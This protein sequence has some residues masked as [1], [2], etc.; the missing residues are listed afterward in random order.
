VVAD[1]RTA[2][3]SLVSRPAYDPNDFAGRVDTA[4][5]KGLTSD[6]WVPLQNR[7]IQNQFPPGS[8][9]KAFVTAATLHADVINEHTTVF[10]PGSYW[11]GKRA[12]RCWKKGGHGT[13]GPARGAAEL[14]ATSSSTPWA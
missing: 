2:T 12:Y 8:T 6:P 3:C 5:W 14:P 7:A 13:R 10:C 9:F 11:Y 1:A 4:T